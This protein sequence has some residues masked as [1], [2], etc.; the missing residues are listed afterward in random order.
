M[1]ETDLDRAHARMTAAPDEDAARAAFYAALGDAALVVLLTGAAQGDQISP[2]IFELD[3]QR[4]A[5][6]FDTEER[7]ADFSG[8]AAAYASVPGRLVAALLAEE[9]IG[10]GLN[11][12]VAPSSILIPPEALVWLTR[13]LSAEPPQAVEA[14]PEELRPPGVLPEGLLSALDA[15]LSRTGGL[16]QCAYLAGVSYAGGGQG[17]LLAFVGAVPGAEDVLARAV[18]EA[19]VFSGIE[20]GAL[21]VGFVPAGSA[22]EARLERVGLRIDP[23]RPEGPAASAARAAP[24]SDPSRPPRLR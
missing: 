17:H 9:G 14:R 12:D 4:F 15:K 23:A 21:D 22:V 5:L 2:E 13:T 10:L 24:G 8:A 1:D 6:A 19:L 7:L 20:A 3:G 18:S 16:V 11:L